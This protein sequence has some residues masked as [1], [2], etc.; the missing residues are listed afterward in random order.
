MSSIALNRA[1][2][3]ASSADAHGVT[4]AEAEGTEANGTESAQ[5][6]PV[7]A[8][9][10]QHGADTLRQMGSQD[11]AQR[12]GAWAHV[13]PGDVAAMAGGPRSEAAP[14]RVRSDAD[15]LKMLNDANKAQRQARKAQAAEAASA[16]QQAPAAAA[17]APEARPTIGQRIG[18]LFSSANQLV[19]EGK[20][21][22][23][24]HYDTPGQT[25]KLGGGAG[26]KAGI[27]DGARLGG[28]R[29]FAGVKGQ[30]GTSQKLPGVEATEYKKGLDVKLG[31]EPANSQAGEVGIGAPKIVTTLLNKLNFSL[32]SSNKAGVKSELKAGVS[33]GADAVVLNPGKLVTGGSG[34]IVHAVE[35]STTGHLLTSRKDQLDAII[36]G[37]DK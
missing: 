32:H 18:N 14:V 36:D 21:K 22:L 5:A 33:V 31:N 7:D 17:A 34:A 29:V 16:Q 2:A 20:D 19:G 15:T 24:S 11:T 1:S 37:Q 35:N 8:S 30:V 13:Q 6:E 12:S 26:A 25:D 28:V 4:A 10:A 23:K 27:D 9:Q 3:S